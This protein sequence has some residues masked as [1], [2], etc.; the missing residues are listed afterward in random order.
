MLAHIGMF[1]KSYKAS[2]CGE[3]DIQFKFSKTKLSANDQNNP[4]QFNFFDSGKKVNMNWTMNTGLASCLWLTTDNGIPTDCSTNVTWA[5]EVSG[6]NAFT[7]FC[8][9]I[10]LGTFNPFAVI[11]N[12]CGNGSF[13]FSLPLFI[14]ISISYLPTLFVFFLVN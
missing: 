7:N 4:T 8:M 2:N 5:M 14:V 12:F 1:Q 10:G 11:D 6:E 9:G 13:I 3:K